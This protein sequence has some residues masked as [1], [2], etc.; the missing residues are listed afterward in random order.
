MFKIISILLMRFDWFL[1]GK[2]VHQSLKLHK[3]LDTL[4][5]NKLFSVKF[6]AQKLLVF[7]IEIF[8]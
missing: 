7:F 8:T 1:N 2:Q 3:S 4:I 5:A 6:I